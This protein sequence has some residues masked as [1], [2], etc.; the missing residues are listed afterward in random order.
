MCGMGR[1]GTLHAWEPEGIAPDI[2]TVGKGLAGGYQAASA[3]LVGQR[4]FNVMQTAGVAFT[5]G[6]TYQNHPVAA[7]AALKVQHIIERDDLLS[8][9]KRQGHLLES[10]LR[11]RLETH[12]NVGDIRG[13]GLFWG[14]EFV[15]DWATKEPFDPVRGISRRVH[16]LALEK[17]D[18]LVYSGQGC[19][20]GGR[21][22]HIMVMPGYTVSEK[23]VVNIVDRVCSAIE[24]FF[25]C[26]NLK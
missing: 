7:A 6:H 19:A 17:F 8:N 26:E 2:Q 5:H 13:K 14:I 1:S 25:S 24:L 9:V 22:D 3:I 4:V 21:G 12:P 15:Q 18:V 10:L 11:R 23:M 16:E 20:G